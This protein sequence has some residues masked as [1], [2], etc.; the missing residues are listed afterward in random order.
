[1]R[2]LNICWQII[3]LLFWLH[4]YWYAELPRVAR[5]DQRSGMPDLSICGTFKEELCAFAD[6]TDETIDTEIMRSR[7][8]SA[9]ICDVFWLR[10]F[11]HVSSHQE[12]YFFMLAAS[13]LHYFT[14]I[15]VQ[16]VGT[17]TTIGFSFAGT[18]FSAISIKR[19]DR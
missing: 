15:V 13:G 8:L 17:N 19:T 6:S 11:T 7:N 16:A 3:M 2:Y 4:T 18:C 9:A 12:K 14:F 5:R 1:M 10:S